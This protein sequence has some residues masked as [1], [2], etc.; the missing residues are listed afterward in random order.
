MQINKILLTGLLCASCFV[1]F[2]QDAQKTLIKGTVQSSDHKP[3]EQASVQIKLLKT[4]SITDD[5][6]SFSLF[7]SKT[8][9]YT[10]DISALGYLPQK[11]NVEVN[12]SKPQ[13]VLSITLQPDSKEMQ[14]V[15]VVGKTTGRQ[16]IESGYNVS[17]VETKS[18]ANSTADLN[19]ILS[20]NAGIRVRESGGLG[21]D[22]N[23]SLNGL[24]GKQVKFFID[25]IPI[26]NFGNSLS[27]NNIPVNLA[28][29][30]EVYKGVVPIEL[31][32]DALGG[33]VNIV[34]NQH[35]KQYLDASYSYGSFN[36]HRA[37]AS[38]RYTNVKTGFTINAS[39]FYNYADN[40]YLMKGIEIE[41]GNGGFV[42]KNFKRF[43]DGFHSAMGQVEAGFRE[44]KWADVFLVGLLYSSYYK[45]RQTGA[46][47]DIVLG[48]VHSYGDVLSP[49]IK[50]KKDN[51]GIDGLSANFYA[52]YIKE[53]TTT[54]DT[55]ANTYRWD[56]S[57]AST[58][59]LFGEQGAFSLFKYDNSYA[60]ARANLAYAINADNSV[61]LSYNLNAGRRKGIN[62]YNEA[63]QDG[64]PLDVP[65]KLDKGI[66][67]LSW[68]N[69]LFD[70]RLST[71]VFGKQ[72]RLHSY[73]RE[74]V[75][76]NSTGYVKQEADQT[77]V[78]Y[79]YGAAT[80][81]KITEELGIKASYEHAYRLPEVAELFGDGITVL[82]NPSLKPEESDNLNLGLYFSKHVNDHRFS[83]EASGFYR[84]A[85]DFINSFPG[86]TFST[87]DNIGKVLI[88]GFDAEVKYSYKDLLSA[89]V[90]GS[91]M[92][93]LNKDQSSTV[94]N[95]RIPN[96]PWLYGNAD[97]GIGKNDVLYKGSR[98]QLNWFTQYVH[99]FYL[100][101]PS[102]G[103]EST[104]SRI[105]EQVI[106]NATLTYSTH[107]GK[108]N[109]SLESR[110][111]FNELAYDNFRLQKPGRS[112]FIKLRYFIH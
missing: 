36:T 71:S 78:Y 49:S 63:N 46:Q 9:N 110:N 8:G 18:L 111:I 60:I 6:G 57:I 24:S 75:Y 68:Q 74:A 54:V 85:K 67:G 72:Y 26:E 94:Y 40:N 44:K 103:T 66:L 12:T 58:N 43:N 53:K 19:Q 95:D 62:T 82:A 33:A 108:Y 105:P 30:V 77:S 112:F 73:V 89:T 99:W 65:N 45:E 109:I 56:G 92:N 10:L 25:G 81:Y 100:S 28:E 107:Q 83:A 79:G 2:S 69:N 4:G 59:N 42:T 7:V 102:R 50:F 21:S 91:Y 15:N 88:T 22:F 37:S 5:S 55:S 61:S 34:T 76:F 17:A 32:A 23:F 31:G 35:V 20:R 98:L 27:L 11:L 70:N 104:K 86:G 1:S 29:R 51:L 3:I 48:K 93:A 39:G 64:N 41:N 52:T 84:N 106:H 38:G 97:I 96:Q 80:R 87:Y 101:W 14:T 13:P 16:L 90:N 47:Q